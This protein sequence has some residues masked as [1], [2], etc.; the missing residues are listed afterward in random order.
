MPGYCRKVFGGTAA[1]N[2]FDLLKAQL[3]QLSEAC[4]SMDSQLGRMTAYPLPPINLRACA[5]VGC[6]A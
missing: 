5:K 2:D 6:G 4:E 3:R 1:G